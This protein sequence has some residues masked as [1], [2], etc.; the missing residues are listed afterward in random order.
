[1]ELL[2]DVGG[3]RGINV[4]VKRGR[5]YIISKYLQ[6]AGLAM[7]LPLIDGMDDERTNVYA[8]TTL[9]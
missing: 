2:G 6:R 1:M 8:R 5:C 9:R 4:V 3:C 7:S